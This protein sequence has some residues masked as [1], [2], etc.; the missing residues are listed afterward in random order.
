MTQKAKGRTGELLRFGL[1]ARNWLLGQMEYPDELFSWIPPEGGK[2]AAEIAEHVGSTLDILCAMI[3]EQL[4]VEFASHE[5]EVDGNLS[6]VAR[7]QIHSAYE[8]FKDL[9][10]NLD[11]KMLEETVT[12]PPQS[13]FREGPVET[14]LRVVAGYHAVHHSGQIA[15]LLKRAKRN[16]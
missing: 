5:A 6:D 7:G 2:S 9:C 3:A 10:G 13:G 8:G 15:T 11:D 14:V 16:Q 12:L 4:D 1:G